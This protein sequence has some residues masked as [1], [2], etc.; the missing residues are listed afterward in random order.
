[1]KFYFRYFSVFLFSGFILK[2]QVKDKNWLLI[3]SIKY[4]Q[5]DPANKPF[6]DSILTIYHK[7][8]NDTVK[9][10]LLMLLAESIEDEPVWTRYNQL[11]YD[12]ADKNGEKRVFLKYKANALNNMGFHFQN[13]GKMQEAIKYYSESLTLREKIKDKNGIANSLN[14]LGYVFDDLHDLIKAEEYYSQGLK[15]REELGEKQGIVNSLN[16]LG[17]LYYFQKNYPK[18]IIYHERSLKIAKEINY[19]RGIGYAL[20]NLGN[21]YRQLGDFTKALEY[22]QMGLKMRLETADAAGLS[23]TYYNFAAIYEQ[24]NDYKKAEE[25]AL[26][27]LDVARH[28]DHNEKTREAAFLLF[29]IY[30]TEKKFEK[31]LNMYLLYI[32][33]RD[34]SNNEASKK[35]S[36]KQQFKYEYEKKEASLK[37]EQDKKDALA[38]TERKKQQLF[39]LLVGAVAIGVAVVAL[40]VIRSL[41]ITRRQ[42]QII[43]NQKHIVEEKQ[44]EILDSIHYARRIQRSLLTSE[45]YIEKNLKKFSK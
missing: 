41:R 42:K 31:A 6:L 44:K 29:G 45:K 17:A 23:G 21:V 10:E 28:A 18:A 11:A 3:D 33:M 43:E 38:A 5:I 16:N 26:K 9:L 24:M 19:K 36:V 25:Y 35:A 12:L 32:Q 30:R 27:A 15:I 4:E 13:I 7:A 14:N 8:N 39:L 22:Q 34:S 1:M 37:A 40:V 2:S 20:N